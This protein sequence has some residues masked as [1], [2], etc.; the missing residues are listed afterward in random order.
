MVLPSL[1]VIHVP[2]EFTLGILLLYHL[3]LEVF[4]FL[5]F[6]VDITGIVTTST[7]TVI[8]PKTFTKP[9]EVMTAMS[10]MYVVATLVLF[11]EGATTRA[12]LG[13][14]L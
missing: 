4:V 10:A 9:A 3:V 5:L 12:W 14:C 6:L 11:N 2:G 8:L 7:R 13:V 1:V